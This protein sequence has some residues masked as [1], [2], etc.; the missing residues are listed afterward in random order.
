IVT[1]NFFSVLGSRAAVGRTFGTDDSTQGNHRLAV[2]SHAYWQNELGGDASVIGRSVTANR[3][4]FTVV[5]IMPPDFALPR[6]AELWVTPQAD[7]PEHAVGGSF[8]FA[9]RGNY[10]RTLIGRLAPGV[11]VA[12]VE[13]EITSILS[14]LPNPNQVQRRSEEHTSELQSRENLVCRLLLEKKKHFTTYQRP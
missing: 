14:Q 13:A 6:E 1:P 8:D 11:T 2:V 12:Q 7:V 4:P 3:I 10:L 5:G 9:G